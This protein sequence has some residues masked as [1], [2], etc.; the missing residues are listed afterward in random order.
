MKRKN[1][2][3]SLLIAFCS[4]SIAI[5]SFVACNQNHA[6]DSSM[7]NNLTESAGLEYALNQDENSYSVVGIG[8]CQD[9][10]IVIPLKYEDKPI[11]GIKESAFNGCE[12][13]TSI[14]IS[15]NITSIGEDAF[16]DTAYYNNE[17]NWEN[18]V[19]YIGK[20]LIRAKTS[21]NG[22]YTIKD[23]TK[24]IASSAFY[25]CDN[26]TSITIPQSVT[27]IGSFV[28]WKCKKLENVELSSNLTAIGT[29]TFYQCENLSNIVIPDSVTSIGG[30]AF[31]Y[32]KKL[33]T[34]QMGD[35]ITSIKS[36]AFSECNSLKSIIIPNSVQ[37]LENEVFWNCYS[38]E[39]I[40]IGSGVTSIS[41]ESFYNCTALKGVYITDIVAWCK[42]EFRG[43]SGNP[44]SCT[45]NLY[46][47]NELITQLVIPETVTMINTYTFFNCGE[48]T[49]VI[50]P[51][52]VK[53]IDHDAFLH[54]SNL[55]NVYYAG[56]IE[57]WGKIKIGIMNQPFMNATRYY[58]SESEPTLNTDGTAYGGNYWHYIDGEIVVWTYVKDEE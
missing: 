41:S 9:T 49:S 2:I 8:A 40:D 52:S 47:N 56:T 35:K 6:T 32:C 17:E 27:T 22:T 53:I 34:V 50:V 23:G 18:G 39:R 55:V 26:L 57:D 37:T 7:G 20:H 3:I 33:K 24:C 14:T 30:S 1:K 43:S 15:E 51:S 54:C 46:L 11:T 25:D 29:A 12:D 5:A 10:D 21:I 28:F 42:I 16:Y 19:L 36:R 58:Y 31:E 45:K 13:L 44:L 4:F 48:I 38:L